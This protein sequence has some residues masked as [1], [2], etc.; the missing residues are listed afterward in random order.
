MITKGT[1]FEIEDTSFPTIV[2]EALTDS[3]NGLFTAR[4]YNALYPFGTEMEINIM[5]PTRIDV[6]R[7]EYEKRKQELV[8]LAA[9]GKAGWPKE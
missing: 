2:G 8:K 1:L 3:E 9:E 4:I 6:S 5:S 7:T